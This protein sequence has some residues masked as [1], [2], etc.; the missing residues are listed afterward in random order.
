[1]KKRELIFVVLIVLHISCNQETS[2]YDKEDPSEKYILKINPG[3]NSG[4]K[5][6]ITNE[7]EVELEVEGEVIKMINKTDA[8][9]NYKITMDSAGKLIASMQFEKIH[10]YTKNGPR[11]TELDADNKL[12]ADPSVQL[13][14]LLKK[15]T[16]I[17][18]LDSNGKTKIISGYKELNDKILETFPST[19]APTRSAIESLWNKTISDKIVNQNTAQL[20]QVFPDTPVYSGSTWEYINKQDGE[21]P[22]SI[23]S[24]F[25]I[26]KINENYA[27]IFS[28]GTIEKGNTQISLNG[29]D[30]GTNATLSGEQK[31]EYKIET[32]TGM[33]LTSTVKGDISGVIGVMGREIPVKIRTTIKVNGSQINKE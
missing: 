11:E 4:Y 17:S 21:L 12:S 15:V 16:F 26:K 19:D 23:K 31:A 10:I 8:S 24:Q 3:K 18:T 22:V 33:I 13:L 20:F 25:I 30:K 32:K 27:E 28:F 6:D 5:Y 2:N 29:I 7:A 9:M 14:G 1:M